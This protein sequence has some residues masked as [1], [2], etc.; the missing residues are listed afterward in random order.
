MTQN[1]PLLDELTYCEVHPT[2]ETS[3][4]CN[5]CGRLMCADCAV[6]TP[7][8]YRCKQCVR[9]HEDRYFT[10]T[11]NDY[12]IIAAICAALSVVGGFLASLVGFIILVAIAAIPVAGFIAEA[13]LRAVK[14]R[15]GRYSGQV[16]AAAVIVGGF[17]GGLAQNYTTF[18]GAIRQAAAQFP[19]DQ[20]PDIAIPF[21]LLVQT[22]VSD[23]GLLIFIGLAAYFVYSRFRLRA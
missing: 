1:S 3:L 9:Q 7:V 19:S 22:T 2:K 6:S 5:K 8:G 17:I 18:S 11:Q 23:I 15:R 14:R 20:V 10:A 12:V 4:R 13:A 16:G 21:D